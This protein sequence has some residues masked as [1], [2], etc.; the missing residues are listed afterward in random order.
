MS[1]C[2][3]FD[4]VEHSIVPMTP[5]YPSGPVYIAS[6][7]HENAACLY[8][9]LRVEAKV[10][11]TN[12]VATLMQHTAKRDPGSQ[13]SPS[14]IILFPGKL[15]PHE[16]IRDS[17][18]VRCPKKLESI[19]NK[20]NLTVLEQRNLSKNQ[21]LFLETYP[22][23]NEEAISKVARY[24][25]LQFQFIHR[26]RREGCKYS[27]QVSLLAMISHNGIHDLIEISS[28]ETPEIIVRGR[29]PASYTELGADKK[30][31]EAKSKEPKESRHYGYVSPEPHPEVAAAL[32]HYYG[33]ELDA[34]V[35]EFDVTDN[36]EGDVHGY[37]GF[38]F[39][40]SSPSLALVGPPPRFALPDLSQS[41]SATD[42]DFTSDEES[43]QVAQLIN[44]PPPKL[45]NGHPVEVKTE[46]DELE[47]FTP[48]LTFD[49]AGFALEAG[50]E[51]SF[52]I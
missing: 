35:S 48:Q 45:S 36:L 46:P 42:S 10:C 16:F 26:S 18:N 39:E 43:T 13:T 21:A 20:C 15:P 17:A 52:E 6:G 27:L 32:D 38:K 31:S 5:V 34:R 14:D 28:C 22:D 9:V 51:P 33:L 37:E 19:F 29:S 44:L 41:L 12:A 24:E 40:A 4:I 50:S 2:A 7:P 3:A 8:F 11:S 30:S 47:E 49:S 25:R 23:A 1:L